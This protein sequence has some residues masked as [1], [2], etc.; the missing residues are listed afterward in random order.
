MDGVE[1]TPKQQAVIASAIAS[2]ERM[3]AANAARRAE[4]KVRCDASCAA[5]KKAMRKRRE[6][7][8]KGKI[9]KAES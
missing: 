9:P 8:E 5:Y 6:L 1:Y 7:I 4:E 2:H 3:M